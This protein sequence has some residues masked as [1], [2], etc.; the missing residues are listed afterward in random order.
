MIAVFAVK[1]RQDD[2]L[3]KRV[4]DLRAFIL[5]FCR[6]WRSGFDLYRKRRIALQE[7]QPQE[8]FL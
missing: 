4:K 6:D 2:V 3:D 5:A 1:M 8:Y 7:A